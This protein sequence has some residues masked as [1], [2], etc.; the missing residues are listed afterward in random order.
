MNLTSSLR[1][2]FRPKKT[3]R[4]SIWIAK[5]PFE[6]EEEVRADKNFSNPEHWHTYKCDVCGKFHVSKLQNKKVSK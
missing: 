4:S 6:S 2:H 1:Q 3:R 5:K